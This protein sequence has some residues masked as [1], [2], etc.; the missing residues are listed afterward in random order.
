VVHDYVRPEYRAALTGERSRSRDMTLADLE[1]NQALPWGRSEE[2]QD[3][4]IAEAEGVGANTLVLHF[5]RGAMPHAMFMEQLYRFG[6]EVLP[7]LQVHQVTK[8]PVQTG[9]QK[10]GL[11]TP[12]DERG[13]YGNHAARYTHCFSI[14]RPSSGGSVC[15]R[16]LWCNWRSR[17]TQTPA[18]AVQS[19]WRRLPVGPLSGAG[20]WTEPA[21]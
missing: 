13:M 16:H 15:A 8:V 5:N 10:T 4:L 12:P 6:A 14:S 7:A 18:S 11:L 2:V 1:R 21:R 19:R 3:K 9:Y 17:E 20:N